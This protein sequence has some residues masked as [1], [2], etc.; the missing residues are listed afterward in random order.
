MPLKPE[1]RA[2][3]DKAV[4]EVMVE[5]R[6]MF[7]NGKEPT[8]SQVVKFIVKNKRATYKYLIAAMLAFVEGRG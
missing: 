4:E 3:I 7:E 5:F 2:E 8:G 6:A 1:E